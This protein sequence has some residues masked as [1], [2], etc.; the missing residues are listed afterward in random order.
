MT[1]HQLATAFFPHVLSGLGGLVYALALTLVALALLFAGRSVVKGLAFLVAGLAGAAF[2]AGLGAPLLGPVGVILG[3]VV[4][5]LVGGVIGVLLVE[6][7]IGL[8]IGY[9]GY[10][11]MRYLT[12]S[13]L[14]SV[15]VGV[16]LFLVGLA[17][18]WRLL[19]LATS[20]LG[21]VIIYGV[22]IFFGLPPFEATVLAVVFAAAGFYVQRE[23]RRRPER[24]RQA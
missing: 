21:G 20:I 19:E 2:G 8:A 13:L 4:G 14:L 11:A 15:V 3:G 5:F 6:L 16:V 10:L 24:W 17:V 23:G 9:F 22:L 7:G 12:G 18:S 1:A